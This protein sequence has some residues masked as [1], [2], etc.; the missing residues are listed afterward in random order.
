MMSV[1]PAVGDVIRRTAPS[2]ANVQS[3]AGH[4]Y[5]VVLRIGRTHVVVAPL[6]AA[7]APDGV[8]VALVEPQGILLVGPMSAALERLASVALQGLAV[9]GQVDR[10]S[11]DR[12]LRG[13]THLFAEAHAGVF[14]DAPAPFRPGETVIAA[15][16]KVIGSPEVVNMVEA[17]L[18]GWLTTG[19][20]NAEFESRLAEFLGVSHVLT[21]NSGSSAN[22]VAFA[23]LTSPRLGPR[24]IGP[25]DEVITVAAGFPTTVNPILQYGAVPVFVDVD[26]TDVQHRHIAP[27]G[28]ALAHAPRRSCSR[29]RS[30]I[31]SMLATV[32]AFARRHG[33][34]LVEDCC[35]A[36]GSTLHGQ[37]VGTFGDI[38]RSASI[39]R[40]TS[41]WAKA[42]RSS[43]RIQNSSRSRESFRDWGRDCYC[44]PGKENTCGKRF[45][46]KL[47]DLPFGYD[48]KYTY[49]HLGF[50]LKITDMQAACAL[51]QIGPARRFH[52]RP[53][54]QLRIPY[55]TPA[56]ARGIPDPCRE[57]TPGAD[58]SWFGFLLTL[59]EA[60]A[61]RRVDLL[62]YL[63]QYKIGTRLLF[64]GNLTRQPSMS[65]RHFRISGDLANTDRIMNDTFWIGVHPGLTEDMLDFVAGKLEAYFGV[66]F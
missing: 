58:P 27:G 63:D 10:P 22:L 5:E 61:S 41:R 32:A 45:C 44:A 3:H 34:W 7:G 23:T 48:H 36:L 52:R 65:G 60:A 1:M 42:A 47:G 19:R 14:L 8:A 12:L 51:A 9:V 53:E 11:V 29:T 26:H 56:F 25:G 31:R 50:N 24:A 55:G 2:V 35:D 49:S 54:A 46:W 43:R 59:R 66:S 39:R 57:A 18:D 33:L 16:G 62:Q 17:S 13:A 40:T 30:A 15:S 37:R 20:F 4:A 28:R 6:E 64:A 38:G 21:V